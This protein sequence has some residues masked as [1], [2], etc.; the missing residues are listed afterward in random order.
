[1]DYA[2]QIQLQPAKAI[3]EALRKQMETER[4]LRI[5]DAKYKLLAKCLNVIDGESLSWNNHIDDGMK[6]MVSDF[7]EL[8]TDWLVQLGK[9][10]P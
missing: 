1:M 3:D 10:T 4:L 7:R 6:G 5:K 8:I 9:E 2:S